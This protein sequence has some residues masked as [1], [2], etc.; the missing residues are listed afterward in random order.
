VTSIRASLLTW[1]LGG[2]AGAQVVA[3]VAIA[4]IAQAGLTSLHDAALLARARTF[5]SLV[6]DEHDPIEFD[7][8]GPLGESNLGVL[9][10]VGTADG[11]VIAASPE[12]PETAGNPAGTRLAPGEHRFLDTR[13]AD[14]RVARRLVLYSTASTDPEAPPEDR[15]RNTPIIVEVIGDS[16]PVARAHR[17]LLVALGLGGAIGLIAAFVAIWL[18]VGRALVPLARLRDAVDRIDPESRVQ[19][20]LGSAQTVELRPIVGALDALLARLKAAVDRERRMTSSIAHEL[21]TPIAELRTLTDV[22]ARWPE[23]ERQRRAVG[24]A[25]DIAREMQSLLEAVLAL[26]RA[27]EPASSPQEAAG[28]IL[29]LVVSILERSQ[30]ARSGVGALCVISGDES[31]RWDIPKGAAQILIRNLLEN[32]L[33]YTPPAAQGGFVAIR[34]IPG[35]VCARL[36]VENGP[37][38]LTPE[39]AGLLFE[40]FWRADEARSDRNHRGL[41]LSIVAAIADAHGLTRSAVLMAHRRL[42]ISIGM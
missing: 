30:A 42:V 26:A 13:T 1:I 37:V 16:A 38:S 22:A 3:G 11:T 28:E 31:A 14:G 27:G 36:E 24:Q 5:A 19:G 15:G 25:A 34:V 21:R 7:Y 8:Y 41:G 12:W 39:Q 33:E 35:A 18:G 20:A 17:A 4:V 6:T 32:A 40:P 29:P 2:V 23:P 10:R 9:V